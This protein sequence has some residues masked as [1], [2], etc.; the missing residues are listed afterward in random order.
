M[1]D[2][3]RCPADIEQSRKDRIKGV[4]GGCCLAFEA[5]EERDEA[6]DNEDQATDVPR[7]SLPDFGVGPI[8]EQSDQRGRDS[9]GDL[10]REKG[11]GGRLSDHNLLEEEEQVVEPA[12]SS[13]IIDEVTDSIC[14][15]MQLAHAIIPILS[16][17]IDLSQLI[18]LHL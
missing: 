6:G 2:L 13:Q 1:A 12:C 18:G 10:P 16:S 3:Q 11:A 4:F 14:P 5:A 17:V 15:D 7:L 9:V 8:A